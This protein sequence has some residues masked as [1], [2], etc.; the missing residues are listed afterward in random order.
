MIIPPKQ[1]DV[2]GR[3]LVRSFLPVFKDYSSDVLSEFRNSIGFGAV[4]GSSVRSLYFTYLTHLDKTGSTIVFT[5]ITLQDMVDITKIAGYEVDSINMNIHTQLPDLTELQKICA[6]KD[7]AGVVLTPLFG[8]SPD[9]EKIIRF[10]RMK[11]IAV[12]IDCAQGFTRVNELPY[13]DFDILMYSFGPI[14]TKTSLRGAVAL[15]SNPVLLDSLKQLINSY[16]VE[17]TFGAYKKTL[18]F[19]ALTILSRPSGY[20]VLSSVCRMLSI[21]IEKLSK[22]ATKVFK[23]REQMIRFLRSRPHQRYIRLLNWQLHQDSVRLKTREEN[24]RRLLGKIEGRLAFGLNPESSFWLFPVIDESESLLDRLRKIGVFANTQSSSLRVVSPRKHVKLTDI[25]SKVVYVPVD[26]KMS[27]I[28][29][30][31]VADEINA[32]R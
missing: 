29:L 10:A 2:D 31:K 3:L 4:A 8:S 11:G 24:G 19:C 6:T 5:A 13:K 16:A 30:D 21:D 9:Y 17:G 28:T 27:N 12:I 32:N 18:K 20:V 22:N 23:N 25:F 7:V 26:S 1:L 15:S 14:K